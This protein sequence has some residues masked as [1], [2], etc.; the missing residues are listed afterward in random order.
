[1]P[2]RPFPALLLRKGSE[3]VLVVS[4]LHIGWE[5]ALAEKGIHVPSQTSKM[6]DKMV[7]LIKASKPTSLIFLGDVK[8][9]VAT[10]ELGEWQDVPYFFEAIGDMVQNIQ[11]TIGNHDGNLEPLLPE[12]VKILPS[13]GVA[14][15]EDFGLFHGHSWPAPELLGC[16]TLII[17]HVQPT[18]TFRDPIGFRMTRQVWVKATCNAA[19]LAKSIFK[20]LNIKVDRNVADILKNRFNTKL[21]VSQLLILP[22]FNRLLGGLPMNQ[23]GIGKSAKVKMFI[24]PIL[25][26]NI[27]DIDNAELYLL[28]G[29]LLGTIN[30]LRNLA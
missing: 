6:L 1:M 24:S 26:S 22:S 10:A 30:Q 13:T 7:Q 15:W 5:I 20:H 28:D 3:R 8:H 23:K 11:I 21:K 18:V 4:D 9:T 12:N 29:T 17:G 19:Q 2:L 25:R 14:L 27:V 16:H